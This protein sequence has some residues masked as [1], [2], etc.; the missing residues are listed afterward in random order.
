MNNI[1]EV[2]RLILGYENYYKVSNLGNVF[3]VRSD[4]NLITNTNNKG[5]AIVQLCKNKKRKSYLVHRLVAE[6]FLENP[7]NY[8]E[9]NHK[10]ENPLNN[11]SNNLEWC[12]HKYNMNYNNLQKRA[13]ISKELNQLYKEE[14]SLTY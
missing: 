6:A 2:W 5:Y 13:R 9:I 14:I 12:T 4:K 11:C 10:D 7:N 8:N 3:S 1:E